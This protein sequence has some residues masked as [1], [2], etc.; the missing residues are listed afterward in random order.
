MC[1]AG[2]RT[3]ETRRIQWQVKFGDMTQNGVEI[4]CSPR[5]RFKERLIS[6]ARQATTWIAPGKI[7]IFRMT[8]RAVRNDLVMASSTQSEPYHWLSNEFIHG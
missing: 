1:P 3:G 8:E 2:L 7:K 6:P 4:W 5:V